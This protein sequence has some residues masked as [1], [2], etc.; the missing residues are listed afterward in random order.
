MCTSILI[1]NENNDNKITSFLGDLYFLSA[2]IFISCV[3]YQSDFIIETSIARAYIST[4]FLNVLFVHLICV[5]VKKNQAKMSV[6]FYVF[7]YEI[8]ALL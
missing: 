8:C 2:W 7:E 4:Y 6:P 5:P 1:I 3:Y